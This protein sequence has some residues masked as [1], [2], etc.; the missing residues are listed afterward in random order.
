MWVLRY[1]V[2][3]GEGTE[4]HSHWL[5]P[6][7]KYTLGRAERSNFHFKS[8]K[9]SKNHL[10]LEILQNNEDSNEPSDL[11]IT[12]L[13]SSAMIGDE[14]INKKHLPESERELPIVRK[15][16]KSIQVILGRGVQ[17][18]QFDRIPWSFKVNSSSDLDFDA[19]R[20]VDVEFTQKFTSYTTHLISSNLDISTTSLTALISGIPI[21][22]PSFL[23]DIID[24]KELLTSNYDSNIPSWK[25]SLTSSETEVRHERL[26]IFSKIKFIFGDLS[27]KQ[28]I[29]G[30]LETGGASCLLFDITQNSTAQDLVQFIES[31]DDP[32]HIV[33]VQ[34]QSQESNFLKSMK[35]PDSEFHHKHIIM[36]ECAKNLGK[37]LITTEDI[38]N[39][40]KDINLEILLRKRIVK[41]Q[42]TTD[43]TN[44]QPPI[45]KQKIGRRVKKVKALDSLDY[46]AGGGKIESSQIESQAPKAKPETQVQE[47]PEV[48]ATPDSINDEQPKK[49]KQRTRIQPLE[50]QMLDT[51][52]QMTPIPESLNSNIETQIPQ[53]KEKEQAPETQEPKSKP[54][55]KPNNSTLDQ[56][57]PIRQKS[58]HTAV[59]DAKRS[60]TERINT[61]FGHD[62][63]DTMDTVEQL[64]DLAIVEVIDIPLR[65]NKSIND[66][67]QNNNNPQWKGRKNFKNFI[68]NTKKINKFKDQSFLI[69]RE[70][71]TM[72]EYDPKRQDV[73]YKQD[74]EFL[75]GI[76]P[77]NQEQH[78]DEEEEHRKNTFSFKN[79]TLRQPTL[80]DNH[81]LQQPTISKNKLF[82]DNDDSDDE[83]SNDGLNMNIRKDYINDVPEFR[84][85]L[86]KEPNEIEKQNN[87]IESSQPI[88]IEESD[89]DIQFQPQNQ[90]Q[91]E[92]DSDDDDDE[93]PK[94]KFRR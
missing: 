84:R 17:I 49:K 81:S 31:L 19:L 18:L 90:H 69:T 35:D 77:N 72:N 5:D 40:V 44:V 50:N 61:Q 45:K 85:Q 78:D 26:S 63:A 92:S 20:K 62:G 8:S 4:T 22:K 9:I 83:N 33:L 38:F 48:Q 2:D 57:P 94:F 43:D 46:F 13:G 41:N 24:Q 1:T 52:Y 89:D 86:D 6:S 28:S 34:L 74:L 56:K 3:N 67:D 71:I 64:K 53:E 37:Y 16:S 10:E 58:F 30:I 76:N 21:I 88:P 54:G 79:D 42:S 32:D 55:T 59:L 39:S 14:K 91:D 11:Q 36:N 12:L 75:K 73:R 82:V 65:Q 70:F 66:N 80:I 93:T 60:A 29:G 87:A 25:N 68:K 15:S 23:S 7:K 51:N 27:Q 47:T